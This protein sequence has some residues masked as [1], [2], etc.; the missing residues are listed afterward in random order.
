MKKIPEIDE[1]R[2]RAKEIVNLVVA[3]EIE[4]KLDDCF[5]DTPFALS[6]AANN[7]SGKRGML[8]AAMISEPSWMVTPL[9]RLFREYAFEPVFSFPKEE[10]VEEIQLDGSVKK[11][12]V[13][14]HGGWISA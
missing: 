10:I 5:T 6:V 11:T 9:T 7:P 3:T 13:I 12:S 1:I 2:K 8:V 4:I 14:K